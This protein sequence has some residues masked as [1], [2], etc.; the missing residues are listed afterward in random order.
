[1]WWRLLR[2]SQQGNSGNNCLLLSLEE[3]DGLQRKEFRVS[4][5]SNCCQSHKAVQIL[6]KNPRML[7]LNKGNPSNGKG[8]GEGNSI[9]AVVC[10]WEVGHL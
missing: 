10:Q 9:L 2:Q 3:E 4:I 5:D 7:I 8:G 6:K 1:M